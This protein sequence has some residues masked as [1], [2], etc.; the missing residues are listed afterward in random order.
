[1]PAKYKVLT[2]ILMK[3]FCSKNNRVT[4]GRENLLIYILGVP[5]PKMYN[6]DYNITSIL[7][8]L[9]SVIKQVFEK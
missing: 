7:N 2:K 6:K 3:N 1:M 8:N 4:F 9:K 5:Y